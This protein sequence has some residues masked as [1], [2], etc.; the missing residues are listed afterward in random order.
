MKNILLL[1]LICIGSLTSCS[2]D[3][4]LTPG[5]IV[6][7]QN[8]AVLRTISFA[9]SHFDIDNL[10]STFSVNIEE[11][12]AT[13]GDILENVQ[14]YISYLVNNTSG[15]QGTPTKEVLL[16]TI[17][18]DLFTRNSVTD[19]L[20][21]QL[22]ISFSE[23][24]QA[25]GMQSSQIS[26]GDQFLVRLALNLTNGLSFSVNDANS[27][28][29]GAQG[30]F[31]SPFCYTINVIEPI[32]PILFTG[33]YLYESVFDGPIGPSFG[34][35]ELVEIMTGHSTNVRVVELE[36][37]LSDFFNIDPLPYEFTFLCEG[38]IME[39]NQLAANSE[40][41]GKCD[42]NSPGML[43]GP[44]DEIAPI[45]VA[46]DSVFELWFVE[47]FNGWDGGCGFENAPSRIRF[48]RQ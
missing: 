19:L 26:C 29:I 28:I 36:H 47:G 2:E 4:I 43:L 9:N 31:S 40:S 13:R 17:T 24:L 22:E 30:F 25:T 8:G 37:I 48:T 32:D 27:Q 35:P 42:L 7:P 46:D 21:T 44:G 14:V 15:G 11:Q 6:E 18:P 38:V 16:R 3:T 1:C 23:A 45:N 34:E 12:D 39:K 20:R 41:D 5:N 33:T 10:E